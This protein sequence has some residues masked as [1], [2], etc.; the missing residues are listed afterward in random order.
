L[1]NSTRLPK[2]DPLIKDIPIIK[3][4]GNS[5]DSLRMKLTLFLF[6]LFCIPMISIRS[7]VVLKIK[8]KITFFIE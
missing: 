6:P 3:L 1:P 5:T 7:N 8:E 2:I 4:I